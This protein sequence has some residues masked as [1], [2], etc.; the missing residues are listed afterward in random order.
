[1]TDSRPLTRR[2][3]ILLI[4][5][6]LFSILV[7][8]ENIPH[9]SHR[10]FTI[11]APPPE[12]ESSLVVGA[13]FVLPLALFWAS[14]AFFRKR[15]H[16]LISFASAAFVIFLTMDYFLPY[17]GPAKKT[18]FMID[19]GRKIYAVALQ[20]SGDEPFLTKQGNP[21]GI[22]FHYTMRVPAGGTYLVQS[23]LS[24]AS[25]QLTPEDAGIDPS[26]SALQAVPGPDEWLT[27]RSRVSITSSGNAIPKFI[28]YN[29]S[30]DEFCLF[31]LA[32]DLLKDNPGRTKYLVEVQVGGQQTFLNQIAVLRFETRNSYDVLEFYESA[33]KEHMPLCA[34]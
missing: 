24:P 10:L 25:R 26:G 13:Y 6:I 16:A 28:I 19:E 20:S 34:P 15:K 23:H 31:R 18:F 12:P 21:I 22:S 29:A 4:L 8:V 9:A 5:G 3:R 17:P 30:K 7:I 2:D 1:M 32:A 33:V 11:F 14:W 27:I